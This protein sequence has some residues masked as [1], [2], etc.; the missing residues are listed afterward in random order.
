MKG[1]VLIAPPATHPG[2]PR[3]AAAAASGASPPDWLALLPYRALSDGTSSARK[4]VRLFTDLKLEES[5]V[6]CL[7][8]ATCLNGVEASALDSLYQLAVH[9]W[10]VQSRATHPEP[11]EAV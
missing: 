7:L 4:E 10:A 8:Q 6:I 11:S 2:M 1:H 9:F 3:A 5:D